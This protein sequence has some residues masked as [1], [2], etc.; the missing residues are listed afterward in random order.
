M[1][2]DTVRFVRAGGKPSDLAM[3]DPDRM[4]YV[5]LSDTTL[6]PCI[7]NYLQEA[8]FE[9]LTPSEGELPLAEILAAVP[10]DVVIGLEMP[11]LSLA[12][13][14]VGPLERLAPCVQS[15]RALVEGLDTR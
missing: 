7:D 3:I 13:A 12:E 4:G 8:T 14:G 11:K 15:G 6:R 2:I 9:R 1:L 10:A 5:Q